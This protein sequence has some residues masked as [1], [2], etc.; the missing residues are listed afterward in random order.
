M[1][2][3]VA[4]A[5][6][7]LIRIE[8][9]ECTAEVRQAFQRWVDE[10]VRHRVAAAIASKSREKIDHLTR[11]RP[12]DGRIDPDLL[13]SPE[14]MPRSL[15]RGTMIENTAPTTQDFPGQR[16]LG[17]VVAGAVSLCIL[18]AVGWYVGDQLRWETYA[19]HVGGKETSPLPDGTSVTLNTDSELRVRMTLDTRDLEL[20]RGEAVINTPHTDKRPL[21]LIV[22]STLIQTTG[23]E[24]DIRKRAS[25][26][27]DL[28]VSN[29]HVATQTIEG[30]RIFSLG[31]S[32]A[33]QS[34]ISAG[35][36]ASI[37]PGDVQVSRLDADDRARRTAWLHDALEFR[38]ATLEQAVE[39]INRFNTRKI[40][41]DDPRIAD[42]RL[43][44]VFLNNDPD[45]FVATL[46]YVIDVKATTVGGENGPGYGTIRLSSAQVR[47]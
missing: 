9:A 36:M 3:L 4:T 2:E 38:D 12:V 7:W 27:V 25:G 34:V 24:F 32:S 35:Y 15:N 5:M 11:L 8:T 14:L 20:L 16:L 13:L 44:G 47:R 45:G 10:D 43:G 46:A 42:R 23:A 17:F 22:D 21:R 6:G 18:C 26:R 39:E 40:V 28:V 29:G 30:L 31:N 41:I 33:T 19:T 37:G 1:R